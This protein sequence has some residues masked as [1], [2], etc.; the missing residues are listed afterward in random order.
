MLKMS[1]KAALLPSFVL[2][3]T[4][5]LAYVSGL[6]AASSVDLPLSEPLV[7]VIVES[8]IYGNILGIILINTEI[9]KP[10]FEENIPE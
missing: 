2:L 3:T 7:I 4:L 10:I 1:A 8:G 9:Q 5:V 6:P